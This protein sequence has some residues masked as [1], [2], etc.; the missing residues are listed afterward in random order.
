MISPS[1]RA[2]ASTSE[3]IVPVPEL[4]VQPEE[5]GLSSERLSRVDGLLRR[6]V[7]SGRLPGATVVVCRRSKVADSFS[8][9][10]RDVASRT[11]MH[12]DTIVRLFSMTKPVTAVAAMML[13][14]EGAFD[15][16]DPVSSFIPSFANTRVWAGG[17]REAPLLEPQHTPMAIWNLFTHTSGLTYGFALDHPVDALYRRAG[18]K[19][20]TMIDLGL[21][22]ACDV[23]AGLPLLFQPGTEWNY[24]VS[25]DV[26]GR[27]VEV[28]SGKTLDAFFKE[29]IFDPLGMTDTSFFVRPSDLGR[30]ATL[31]IPQ[32]GTGLA[33]PLPLSRPE[34][35]MNPP[36]F[37]SG[38][39]GL[40]GT[41]GDYVR[42]TKMLSN[43]GELDGVRLLAPGTLEF[44]T[45]NHLPGGAGLTEIGRRSLPD[46]I[47][48]GTGFGLGFAVVTDPVAAKMPGPAGTYY[49]GGAAST[50]FFVDPVDET[51][52]VFLTQLLPSSTYPI[53]RQLR[54]LLTQSIVD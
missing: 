53:R 16:L 43:G 48:P 4:E 54:Q 5:V 36:R 20:A 7:D 25:S 31:Y 1:P 19:L 38:G 17:N 13:Y 44:M 2:S 29:R 41:A 45:K 18:F 47:Q 6:Y 52:V 28:V 50:A 32:R 15:L 39:G 30:L 9:G 51:T 11:P 26:L 8:Y 42:F 14:E 37:L 34:R 35:L 49:W 3:K 40:Y 22:E 10:M 46:L 33:S 23:I 27:I 24:S 12:P 21:A